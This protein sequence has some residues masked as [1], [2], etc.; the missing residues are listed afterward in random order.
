M[1]FTTASFQENAGDALAP[2]KTFEQREDFFGR[3]TVFHRRSEQTTG[4]LGL[5]ALK[6]RGARVD[7]FFRLA[8]PL[9]DGA[10]GPFDVRPGT[11]VTAIDEQRAGPDVDGKLVLTAKVMIET[12]EKQLFQTRFPIPLRFGRGRRE[13]DRRIRRHEFGVPRRNRSRL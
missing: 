1:C 13:A 9:G 8:L 3:G 4:G 12:A 5:A 7:E 10:A 11:G 6:R 2:V